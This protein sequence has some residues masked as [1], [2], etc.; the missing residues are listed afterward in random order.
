LKSIPTHPI[1]SQTGG[2]SAAKVFP[3]P[4][5]A[6]GKGPNRPL[7]S[8]LVTARAVAAPD[9]PALVAGEQVVTYGE[10][11]R[12][13]NRLARYLRSL[14]IGLEQRVGICAGRSPE[15]VITALAALKAG[16]GYVPL[17]PDYPAARL[18]GM[19]QDADIPLL[20]THHEIADRIGRGSW[21]NLDV[22]EAEENA[23]E[24]PA[25]KPQVDISGE[26]LAYII[27][28]SGS[29]GQ[30]K[31]VQITHKNLLN[32]VGWHVN[33]FQVTASDRASQLASVG[34]DA[35]VWEVWPQLAVGCSLHF[36]DEATRLAPEPLRDWLVAQGIT[37]SFVPTPLAEALLTLA[38]PPETSLRVMLT[39]GD[40]LH[41]YPAPDFPFQLVNNYGPTECTVV[42]TSGRVAPNPEAVAPPSIG[43]AIDNFQIYILDEH[44]DPVAPG[45]IGE[46]HIAGAGVGRGYVNR[47]EL[48]TRKFIPNPFSS[49][50]GDRMYKTGDLG[51]FLPNGE[52]AFA[53]RI[54]NQIKM[55][56]YRIEPE[57]IVMRLNQC[58]GV[59]AS[60]V[61][62][63]GENGDT[64]LTAYLVAE[65][66]A[67]LT[68]SSLQAQL[69][70]HLPDYMIPAT[71]V[72]LAGLPAPTNGKLDRTALPLPGPENTIGDDLP[73]PPST[74][75]EEGVLAILSEL[76]GIENLSVNDNF[77]FLGGHSLL[78]TQLIAR[79]RDRFGVELS[80]RTVFDAPTA[81]K[82]SAEIERRMR[83][84]TAKAGREL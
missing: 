13:A 12:R 14:G 77:F 41:R 37:I 21:K 5:G 42:A 11:E 18:R 19:L 22:E 34:F 64:R 44:L 57:E 78:G 47:H 26:N 84:E 80:L 60:V 72:R 49:I 27:Y 75:L 32:L 8:E 76:L 15:M 30:P 65:R 50:P 73:V 58:G 43:S 28:T 79:A 10:L 4:Q 52:I 74:P 36:P 7:V 6:N 25:E 70:Q 71:F 31:G 23:A 83:E 59:K 46:L 9:S 66:G 82:L 68:H 53:G 61:V 20:I 48:E 62:A 17:D 69:K 39:G 16:A 29:S 3:A 56:G 2:A 54:D 81:S 55:R 67:K 45:T 35:V 40:A 24:F 63:R 1:N 38:W 51:F 33:A